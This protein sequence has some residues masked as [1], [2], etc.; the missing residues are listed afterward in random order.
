MLLGEKLKELRM[1]ILQKQNTEGRNHN[2]SLCEKTT[3]SKK[4]EKKLCST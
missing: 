3:A 4:Q 1:F 2:L